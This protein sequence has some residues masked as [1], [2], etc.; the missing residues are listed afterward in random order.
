MNKDLLAFLASIFFSV[1]T[2][3]IIRRMNLPAFLTFGIAISAS[4]TLM[5]LV[6]LHNYISKNKRFK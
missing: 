3:V 2:V 6:T 5:F 1:I 4:Y